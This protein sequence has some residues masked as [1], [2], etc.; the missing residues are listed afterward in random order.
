MLMRLLSHQ[1]AIVSDTE[2]KIIGLVAGYGSG[3]SYIMA[4]KSVLLMLANP[5]FDGAMLEPTYSLITEILLPEMHKALKE[6][7]IDYIYKSGESI[8]YCQVFDKEIG[9]YVETRIIL[10]SI[11][12]YERLIGLNLAWI[13]ADEIDTARADLG[14]KAYIKLLGRLRVGNIKQ[15]CL[16]ST[17]EGFKTLYKIFV[18]ED[19]EDKRLIR[20][21]STDNPYLPLDF[22]ETMKAQYSEELIS[23]YINGEFTNLASGSVY[24]SYDRQQNDTGYVDDK[25][26]DLVIGMDFNIQHMAAVVGVYKDRVLKIFDEFYDYYD[27]PSLIEAIKARYPNRKVIVYPDASGSSR[28]AT[29]GDTTN[30]TLLRAAGFAIRTN[31]ANPRI[32][33]RVNTVNAA[34]KNSLDE[35]RLFVST[36]GCPELVKALEQ[37]A[38]DPKT[39]LPAK[40]AKDMHINDGCG[41]LCCGLLPIRARTTSLRQLNRR[42]DG[43]DPRVNE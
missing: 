37:D 35:T 27:T 15:F 41:Y 31:E 19:D 10:K 6:F 7:G 12:N 43:M 14:Y 39:H 23:A 1:M 38:Y 8:F 2:H 34:L 18:E 36:S 5:G 42:G 32:L 26:S 9:E 33:D 21:K 3:K 16:Y 25:L 22:I 4:R 24:P 13:A 28:G 29:G 40:G 30:H 11:E 20:A 17:P